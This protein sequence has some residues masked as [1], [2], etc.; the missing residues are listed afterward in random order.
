MYSGRYFSMLTTSTQPQHR[1]SL[2][3]EQPHNGYR[4]C[5]TDSRDDA[6]FL[7]GDVLGEE[8]GDDDLPGTD[9]FPPDRSVGVEDP[10][11]SVS[12]D[13]ATREL[14]RD[15]GSD[16]SSPRFSLVAPDGEQG[17]SDDE[18]QEIA[19]AVEAIDVELSPE[20]AALHIIPSD[21]S[22]S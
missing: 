3:L 14:R 15:V 7:D 10:T 16:D 1:R 12:D 6:E 20:E 5:M 11:R 18:S 19:D 13:F 8:A 22:E 21:E 4:G 17:L 9:E 2:G